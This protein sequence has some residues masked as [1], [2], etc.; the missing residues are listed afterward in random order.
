MKCE[1]YVFF[2]AK[3]VVSMFVLIWSYENDCEL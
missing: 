3:L 2:F 1:E